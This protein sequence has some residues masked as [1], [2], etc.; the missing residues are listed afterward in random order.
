LQLART[1]PPAPLGPAR[2]RASHATSLPIDIG[3]PSS[4]SPRRSLF[5]VSHSAIDGTAGDPTLSD[6]IAMATGGGPWTN[7]ISDECD[8]DAIS[9]SSGFQWT[10]GDPE[11]QTKVAKAAPKRAGNYNHEE[12]IQLCVSWE[13]I[14]THPFIGNEQPGR[15]YWKRTADHYHANKT[16]ES[17]RNANSLEHR[18]ST[19]QKECQKFQ[20]YYDEVEHH[21]PSGIPYKEHVSLLMYCSLLIILHSF[22]LTLNFVVDS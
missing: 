19:I 14:S 21:H 20:R 17:D 16:F 11:N 5:H 10:F 15:A 22:V 7:M 8:V 6:E 4:S 3:N 9:L 18:W 2:S 12:D 1:A 13:N